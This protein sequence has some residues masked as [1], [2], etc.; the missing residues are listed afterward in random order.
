MSVVRNGLP[1]DTAHKFLVTGVLIQKEYLNTHCVKTVTL[2][3]GKLFALLYV[4]QSQCHRIAFFCRGVARE[5]PVADIAL[6]QDT[7]ISGLCFIAC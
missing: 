4:F 5:R 1:T 7:Q 6:C 3:K 2:S